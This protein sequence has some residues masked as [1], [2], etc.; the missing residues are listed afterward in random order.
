MSN[1][2]KLIAINQSDLATMTATPAV[3]ATL[4]A[5]NLQ[6]QPRAAVM[7]TTSTAD[8]QIKLTWPSAKIL[9][10]AA[11]VRH[12]LTSAA[13]WSMQI[14]S[15]AAWTTLIYDSG[16]VLASPAKA[17]GDLTWGVDPL[18]ASAFTGWSYAF[19]SMYFAPVA[20]QSV[21]IT[22]SD[23][24]N[25]AGYLEA[26]RLF[27][28]AHIEPR[29]TNSYGIKLGWKEN[30]VTTRT[31]GGS[32]RSDPTLPYRTLSLNLDW[33]VPEDRG[34]VLDALRYVGKR[35]DI[36]I[37]IYPGSGGALERD[38]SMTAKIVNSPDMARPSFGYHTAQLDLEE[39]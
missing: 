33:I 36:W 15:D 22:L 38:Y 19:S 4:P 35:Q 7:R 31:D 9:S 13:T 14:Y 20:A 10:G 17:L 32:L 26:S 12:N 18:G 2:L 25:P 1:G 21:K 28:G 3:V 24:G 23:A 39:S 6:V 27:L 34:V 37:T 11:L 5:S 30:T 8:Q 29:Y 16:A